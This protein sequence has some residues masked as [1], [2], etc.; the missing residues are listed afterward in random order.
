MDKHPGLILARR[1]RISVLRIHH[2]RFMDHPKTLR[3][4]RIQT[5]STNIS[6][7]PPPEQSNSPPHL[8]TV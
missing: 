8:P 7:Q 1:R 2:S 5:H 6:H 3:T 4:A